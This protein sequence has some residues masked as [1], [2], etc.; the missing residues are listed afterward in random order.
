[1]SIEEQHL[2]KIAKRFSSKDGYNAHMSD[3]AYRTIRPFF[4]GRTCL[5]LGSSD[6][7]MTPKL[8]LDFETVVAVDGSNTQIKRLREFHQEEIS[9]ERLVT[10]VSLIENLPDVL[11][12]QSRFDTIVATY[13]LE[14]VDNPV[15]TLSTAR[16]F[17]ERNG[18]LIVVV[19]NANSIHR[20][21]G[22]YMGVLESRTDLSEQD[23]HDGHR[24]T[25]TTESLMAD[26]HRAGLVVI[27]TG[28]ILLKPLPASQMEVLPR[29]VEE[30]FFKAGQE[31]PSFCSSIFVVGQ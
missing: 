23:H 7:Q 22:Q 8:L 31:F 11:P 24:R 15:Q 27:R 19:P 26:F 3:F 28:G 14:H 5:E 2:E 16:K 18:V 17:L 4:Q 12:T 25:Y 20:I 9:L 6:G 13:L 1:M 30:G 29:N 21:V 10:Y